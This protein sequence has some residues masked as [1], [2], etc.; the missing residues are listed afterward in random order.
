M[1]TIVQESYRLT[2]DE[3]AALH[4]LTPPRRVAVR[5][6]GLLAP[7]QR[8]V[9]QRLFGWLFPHERFPPSLCLCI[10]RAH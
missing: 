8:F 10:L 2:L 9:S 4:A 6:D 1:H 5:D 7:R 3:R